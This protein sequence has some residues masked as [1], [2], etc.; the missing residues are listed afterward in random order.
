M[1]K[2]WTLCT[3]V[4][5]AAVTADGPVALINRRK[6]CVGIKGLEGSA[7]GHDVIKV[8]LAKDYLTAKGRHTAAV[9]YLNN[10]KKGPSGPIL[11]RQLQ[12]E[13]GQES[14]PVW[15]VSE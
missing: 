3:L 8:S 12:Q 15:Q 1:A 2:I 4:C 5:A 6:M 9:E 11:R 7:H 14:R 13:R 10:V